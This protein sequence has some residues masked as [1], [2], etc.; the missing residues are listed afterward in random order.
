MIDTNV[1]AVA[2]GDAQQAGPDCVLTCIDSLEDAMRS[3]LILLDDMMRI[4]D[5]YRQNLSLSGQP[6]PGDRFLKWLWANQANPEH[7]LRVT[8]IPR[9][10]NG[11]DFQEFPQDPALA[12]FHRKDRKFV[13]V[14]LASRRDPSI[15][16]ASDTDWWDFKDELARH[17]L[18]IKFLCPDLM[19]RTR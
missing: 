3:R 15:H 18:H 2:N 19:D 1:A 6:G 9:G 14:A 16:N 12:G 11:E 5:E 10:S 7:C 8:I 4:L 13:A 17:G